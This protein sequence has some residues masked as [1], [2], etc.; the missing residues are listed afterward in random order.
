MAEWYIKKK[1][2]KL[3]TTA[4]VNTFLA[5][6]EISRQAAFQTQQEIVAQ[7]ILREVLKKIE[8]PASTG[9]TVEAAIKIFFG[10]EE[11]AWQPY[12]DAIEILKQLQSRRYRLGLYSNATDDLL[13]QRL[14]NRCGLRPYLSPTFSSA[15]WGWRKPRPEGFNLIAQRW[16][17]L[18]EEVAVVGDDLEADI[19]GAHNAGMTGILVVRNGSG[20]DQPS[21]QPTAI[22]HTLSELPATIDHL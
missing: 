22:I 21:I 2:I 12:P 20:P 10:P 4:L 6:R 16:G 8:A 17:L 14:V 19:Q 15:G 1:H 5:E 7:Q 11:E 9:P 3:N 13:I 18:P